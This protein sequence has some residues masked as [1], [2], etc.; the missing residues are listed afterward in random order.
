MTGSP[1]TENPT[2]TSS[3]SSSFTGSSTLAESD[4]TIQVTTAGTSPSDTPTLTSTTD[5]STSP[6]GT[7][8]TEGSEMTIKVTTAGTTPSETSTSTTVRSTSSTRTPTTE[9]SIL[10]TKSVTS[11]AGQS[12]TTEVVSTTVNPCSNEGSWDGQKCICQN[13]YIGQFCEFISE[14]V[15]G[16]VSYAISVTMEIKNRNYTKELNSTNSPTFKEFSKEFQKQMEH[17][18]GEIPGYYKSEIIKL[19]PGSII[20]D[21]KALFETGTQMFDGDVIM[22]TKTMIKRVLEEKNC[23]SLIVSERC[24]GFLL[25]SDYKNV[26]FTNTDFKVDCTTNVM[27]DFKTYYKAENTSLG[28]FC[29]SRCHRESKDAL[30]CK[31]GKCELTR[32]GPTCLCNT[33]KKYWYIG[34]NCQFPVNI[35]ALILV[36]VAVA[37]IIIALL[38]TVV[39]YYTRRQYRY[40][41]DFKSSEMKNMWMEDKWDWRGSRYLTLRNPAPQNFYGGSNSAELK[42]F[43]SRFGDT[44]SSSRIKIA[45]PQ[46][47]GFHNS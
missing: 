14:S 40:N 11:T 24:E 45:R 26:S 27:D 22:K 7:L 33:S 43:T 38:I 36:T 17:I 23:T 4:T 10:T 21:H 8:T 31:Y 29:I 42:N 13:P 44:S 47:T 15:Q 35:L 25:S 3:V 32:N 2:A 1:S 28:W 9:A 12:I 18:Y 34:E 37:L 20:V 41:G 16:N 46:V 5:V 6:T 19:S 39:V 30:Q